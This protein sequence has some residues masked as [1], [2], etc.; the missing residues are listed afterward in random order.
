MKA[1]VMFAANQPLVIEEVKVDEPQ[2]G[3]ALIKT[4]ASGVC[5]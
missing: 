5:H 1:A 2:A 3:E 4:S